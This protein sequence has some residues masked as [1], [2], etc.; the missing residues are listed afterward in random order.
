MRQGEPR[1]RLD[2]TAQ[3]KIPAFIR[4]ETL[5]VCHSSWFKQLTEEPCT[6]S[7]TEIKVLYWTQYICEL[8]L[9]HSKRVQ[10]YGKGKGGGGRDKTPYALSLPLSPRISAG[11]PPTCVF[12]TVNEARRYLATSIITFYCWVW[13]HIISSRDVNQVLQMSFPP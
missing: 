1:S 7:C 10:G 3:L 4:N 9:R 5:I 11:R 12:V 13:P 6:L 2:V 8:E